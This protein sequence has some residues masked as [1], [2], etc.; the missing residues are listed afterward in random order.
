MRCGRFF[1]GVEALGGCGRV[2][3][4]GGGSASTHRSMD[5]CDYSGLELALEMYTSLA[6]YIAQERH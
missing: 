4:V 6:R 3:V 1:G 5:S 2:G